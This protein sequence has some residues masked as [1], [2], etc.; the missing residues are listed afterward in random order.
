M[1]RQHEI[2]IMAMEFANTNAMYEKQQKDNLALGIGNWLAL[3]AAGT[4]Q[5]TGSDDGDD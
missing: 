4:N 1:Q 3:R 2:G 5:G